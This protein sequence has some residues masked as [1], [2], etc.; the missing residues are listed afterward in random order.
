MCTA[1]FE[2]YETL[3]SHKAHITANVIYAASAASIIACGADETLMADASIMMIHNTQSMA[4]GDYR[5]MAQESKAYESFQIGFEIHSR[6]SAKNGNFSTGLD[7]FHGLI[8]QNGKT[9]RIETFF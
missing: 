9:S 4:E 1:G 2:I 5:D 7:I 8:R 6:A 3:R